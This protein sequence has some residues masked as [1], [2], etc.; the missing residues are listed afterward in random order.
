MAVNFQTG[1]RNGKRGLWLLGLW[2]MAWVCLLFV[3]V[4][5][6]ESYRPNVLVLHSYHKAVWSDKMFDG[7]SSVLGLEDGPNY[8]IE[9]MDTKK[10]KTDEYLDSLHRVYS[11]K[12]QQMK[13]DV[14]IATDD[15]AY[16]FARRHHQE[17]LKNAPLVFCG[18]SQFSPEEI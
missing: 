4:S 11:V 5:R 3:S 9:Y 18:V 7:I 2:A 14:V 8:F 6:A 13:F 16:Q 10:I 15:N 12:Y 1:W 17:L